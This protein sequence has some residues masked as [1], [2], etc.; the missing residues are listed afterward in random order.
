MSFGQNYNNNNDDKKKSGREVY[1]DLKFYHPE[2]EVDPGALSYS[3][4]NGMMK[5]SISPVDKSTLNSSQPKYDHKNAGVIYLRPFQAYI[6]AQ[7]FKNVIAGQPQL[8]A[9]VSNLSNDAVIFVCSGSEFGVASPCL[10]IRK[11]DENGNIPST[12]VYQF[13]TNYY[14]VRNFDTDTKDFEKYFYENLELV[15]FMQTVEDF[16]RSM[17]GAQAF[18]NAHYGRFDMSRTQ[19]KLDS[20]A[21]KLGI[22]YSNGDNKGGYGKKQSSIFE[23]KETR[24]THF[25][26]ADPDDFDM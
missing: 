16:A 19:T 6:L 8:N 17:N 3:F 15:M 14:A 1:G 13:K 10:A 2:A 22:T 5:I 25:E 9:G 21:E 18:A 12:Y 24:Q 20:I 23:N 26:V 4:W 11:I 7:E